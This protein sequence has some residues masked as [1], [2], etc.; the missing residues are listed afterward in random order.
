MSKVDRF[1]ESIRQVCSKVCSTLMLSV[2]FLFRG[3][4]GYWESRYLAGNTSG[5]GSYG[6]WAEFKAEV[7]NDFV[8]KHDILSVTEFGCGD[9]NQL[10]LA[11]YPAYTGLDISKTAIEICKERF[12][13]DK[14]KI[15]Q[16]Y[17]P[18]CFEQISDA[19]QADLSM[20]LDVIYHLVED[21]IFESYMK[22]LFSV[23]QRFV[24]IYSTDSDEK[25]SL[26]LPHVR[27]RKFSEWVKINATEWELLERI[28][29]KYIA[30][31]NKL[32]GASIDF[33][34]YKRIDG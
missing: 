31:C 12:N 33:F 23:A 21:R 4:R 16:Q 1:I 6:K 13:D 5:V 32:A 28:P 20:S 29:N 14:M 22:H 11:N 10:L 15:F 7:L 30:E 9:G 3:S 8:S 24:V 27:H 34:I 18:E 19:C 17:T 25:N 26:H 2:D